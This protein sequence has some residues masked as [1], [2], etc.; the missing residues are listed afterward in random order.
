MST[1]F[2]PFRVALSSF[3]T[4]LRITFF[5]HKLRIIILPMPEKYWE[6]KWLKCMEPLKEK[7]AHGKRSKNIS[8]W[9]YQYQVLCMAFPKAAAL[10]KQSKTQLHVLLCF[11]QSEDKQQTTHVRRPRQGALLTAFLSA[12]EG[13][14]DSINRVCFA[15]ENPKVYMQLLSHQK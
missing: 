4:S 3:L 13:I 1:L 15:S 6:V 10:E 9:N 12:V 5:I 11:L 14:T 7:P 8:N 2:Y